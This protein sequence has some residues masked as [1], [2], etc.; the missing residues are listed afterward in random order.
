MED[1]AF[2]GFCLNSLTS[3]R[4]SMNDVIAVGTFVVGVIAVLVLDRHGGEGRGVDGVGGIAL[5]LEELFLML[6]LLTL[7]LLA[8]MLGG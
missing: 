4:L 3:S 5:A 7:A 2:F 6:L 1:S 8:M